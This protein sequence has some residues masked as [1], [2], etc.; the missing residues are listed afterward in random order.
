MGVTAAPRLEFAFEGRIEIEPPTDLGVR[1]GFC[2]RMF[3]IIGGTVRGPRLNGR[4]LPGGVDHQRIDPDGVVFLVATYVVQANDGAMIGV[5]NRGLRHGPVEAM[6]RSLAGET[7]DPSLFYFRTAPV[8][9][10]PDGPHAWLAR[11]IFV[12]TAGREGQTVVL[13]YFIVF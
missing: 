2:R 4:V 1:S 7:V 13:R 6:A 8:F 11:H 9:E 3:P 10:P 5:V 12:C